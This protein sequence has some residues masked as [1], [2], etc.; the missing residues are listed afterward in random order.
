MSKEVSG[1]S[2]EW[3]DIVS[4]GNKSEE[5]F[6][7]LID[8]LEPGD[9][10]YV[11]NTSVHSGEAVTVVKIENSGVVPVLAWVPG[12]G[13]DRWFSPYELLKVELDEQ[14]PRC[15]AS[16]RVINSDFIANSLNQIFFKPPPT[17]WTHY[18]PTITM[19]VAKTRL[20]KEPNKP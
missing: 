17:I 7:Q 18:I 2:R 5:M 6:G 14:K 9:L 12:T 16:V 3:F 10:C 19:V 11:N 20:P 1:I 4:K 15:Y 8:M 13:G